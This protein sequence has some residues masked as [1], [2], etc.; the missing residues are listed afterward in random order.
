MKTLAILLIASAAFAQQPAPEPRPFVKVDAPVIALTH[1][2]VIDGTGVAP[3]DDQTVVISA[4]K[5][6][7]VGANA[8]APPNAK[9]LDLTGATVFPGLVG[10]HDHMFFP[11]GGS[12]PMYSNMGISF[13]TLYLAAGITTIRTT[14]R[15]Q[16]FLD[17][18]I[19]K[20]IDAGKMTGP[21]MYITAPYLEGA[22]AYTPVMHELSGP[23]D[24]RKMVNF[25]AD[26]G[27]TS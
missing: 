15:V 27:A 5:I 1:V 3:Q 10:M 20:L 9:V 7:S 4:G 17:L 23:D 12:P 2:R 19:K 25:W 8:A 14:G 11:M 18:E 22:G 13:P 21:A 24:A 6:Q 16:P 26:E